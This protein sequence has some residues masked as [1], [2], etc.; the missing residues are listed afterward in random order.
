MSELKTVSVSVSESTLLS[1]IKTHLSVIGKRLVGGDGSSLY[2][3]VTT[4]SAEDTA[5]WL[6][7]IRVGS[8]QIAAMCRSLCSS[9]TFANNIISFAFKVRRWVR[10]SSFAEGTGD[11]TVALENS[12]YNY[13]WQFALYRYLSMIFPTSTADSIASYRTSCEEQLVVIKDLLFVKRCPS[14]SSSDYSN[15]NG[16]V[17]E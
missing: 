14:Y 17:E 10:D 4:S 2:S 8:E 6:D 16:E 3:K 5:L 12:I 9:Y 1:K 11:L 7:L 13:L 15:I